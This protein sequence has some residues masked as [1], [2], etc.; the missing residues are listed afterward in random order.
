MTDAPRDLILAQHRA[1]MICAW[2]APVGAVALGIGVALLARYI[3]PPSPAAS[4]ADIVARYRD[5]AL[6]IRAGLAL[7]NPAGFLFCAW[8][9]AIA[10][11]T[12]KRFPALS[13]LQV[14]MA[15]LA[16]FVGVMFTI[17]GQIATFRVGQIDPGITMTLNDAAMFSFLVWAPFDL[18]L[19]ALA[20]AILLDP[21]DRPALPRWTAWLSIWAAL[22]SFPA[23]FI[24]FAKTGPLAYNGLLGYYVPFVVFFVWFPPMAWAVI[25]ATR[26]D[27][28]EA[29]P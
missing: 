19:I 16:F 22:L 15:S 13:M 11:R 4:A 1:Q 10:A 5:H 24:S 12:W 18:W 14:T 21:S 8:A 27:L 26:N 25:R 2:A 29:I 3:P 28:R 17:F 6:G 7:A 9:C 23:A 20:L